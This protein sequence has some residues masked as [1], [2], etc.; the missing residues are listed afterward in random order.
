MSRRRAPIAF[1]AAISA[2]CSLTSVVIVFDSSTSAETSASSV[3]TFRMLAI[4]SKSDLP[5]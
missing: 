4:A 1:I 3:T 2:V 5:G